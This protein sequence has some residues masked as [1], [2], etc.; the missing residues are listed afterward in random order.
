MKST[1]AAETFEAGEIIDVGKTIFSA[2][3]RLPRSNVNMII[4]F[5]WMDVCMALTQLLVNA[6]SL[7]DQPTAILVSYVFSLKPQ[8]VLQFIRITEKP[9]SANNGI[10]LDSFLTSA[11]S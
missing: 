4:V 7:T 9:N 1:G 11:V 6:S 8:A 2:Y 3:M 5:H 10:K